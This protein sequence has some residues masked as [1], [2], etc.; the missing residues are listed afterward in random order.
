[1]KI[2]NDYGLYNYIGDIGKCFN[3]IENPNWVLMS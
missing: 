3:N 2:T 1:M